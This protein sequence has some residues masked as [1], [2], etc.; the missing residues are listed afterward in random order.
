MNTSR[1]HPYPQATTTS[2]RAMI[3][4]SI[5]HREPA[6]SV[7][8]C[9]MHQLLNV[10][11]TQKVKY[12]RSHKPTNINPPELC[13]TQGTRNEEKKEE[14][15]GGS[16]RQDSI[17]DVL[18]KFLFRWQ[19]FLGL[20]NRIGGGGDEKYAYPNKYSPCFLPIITLFSLFIFHY[21]SYYFVVCTYISWDV[22]SQLSSIHFFEPRVYNRNL[23]RLWIFLHCAFAFWVRCCFLSARGL[24]ACLSWCWLIEETRRMIQAANRE[25][26]SIE[27]ILRYTPT[28]SYL[29]R[30]SRPVSGRFEAQTLSS[31]QWQVRKE[32][33][34]R[35]H[36]NVVAP[37]SSGHANR[38]FFSCR[39]DATRAGGKWNGRNESSL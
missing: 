14:S 33:K 13:T 23:L 8:G 39:E 35:P 29:C 25:F 15:Y 21:L 26:K 11:Y 38:N 9:L 37:S 31:R 17:S 34:S 22:V 18:R 4:R 1:L 24:L 30:C 16:G 12:C 7:P 27:D 2:L 20:S 5:W 19:F 6:A 32:T 3:R 10:R 36:C 28:S